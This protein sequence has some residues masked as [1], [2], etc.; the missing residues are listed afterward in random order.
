MPYLCVYMTQHGK[1]ALHE[2][3]S[4]TG[5]ALIVTS[6]LLHGAD[7]NTAPKVSPPS[8]FFVYDTFDISY[9]EVILQLRGRLHCRMVWLHTHSLTYHVFVRV[10][11]RC[12]PCS[13]RLPECPSVIVGPP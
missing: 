6:L 5:N 12:L 8:D 3:L 10:V 9:L 11:S 1:T 4:S 2:A 13:F 7:P